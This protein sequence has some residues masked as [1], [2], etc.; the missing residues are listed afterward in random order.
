MPRL[1]QQAEVL[2][3]LS[4]I[5]TLPVEDQED[6]I[7][8]TPVHADGFVVGVHRLAGDPAPARPFRVQCGPGPWE[9]FFPTEDEALDLFFTCLTEGARMT[10]SKRGGTEVA[11]EL[12]LRSA[13]HTDTWVT[14]ATCR[15][16]LVAFWHPL[17]RQHLS[18]PFLRPPE[19][20][21][22]GPEVPRPPDGGSP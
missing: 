18:N 7:R 4:V 6:G 8:V 2:R 9:C 14:L 16:W 1:T 17:T 20:L 12:E 3:E 22:A 15:R 21:P 13:P 19:N 5:E 11:W 10:V